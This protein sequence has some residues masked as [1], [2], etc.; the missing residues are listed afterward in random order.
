MSYTILNIVVTILFVGLVLWKI[1]PARGVKQIREDEVHQL[2]QSGEAQLID[3]RKPEEYQQFHIRGFQ[4]IPL[5]EIKNQATTLSKDKPVVTVCQTGTKGN[6]A[7]KRL[8]RR[9]FH[10]LSNIQGGLSTLGPTPV[11]RR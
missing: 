2:M 5:K 10:Q 6:E 4:N 1:L 9:G 8:K 11:K 7:C 3:V